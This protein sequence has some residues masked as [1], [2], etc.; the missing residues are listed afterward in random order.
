[1][2]LKKMMIM[3]TI[4]IEPSKLSS[5]EVF[6]NSRHIGYIF[7][8]P[9]DESFFAFTEE[10]I[11][12]KNR[13]TL[14]QSFRTAIGVKKQTPRYRMQLPPFFSNLLPEG[15]LRT[16]LSDRLGIHPDREFFFL[17]E[18][19]GDLPGA[20]MVQPSSTTAEPDS[21]PKLVSA[22]KHKNGSV[23]RFSLAGVQL[24]FSAVKEATG[25]LTI[26]AS[27]AGGSWIL[28]LPGGVH[29]A[30]TENEYSMLELARSVGINI[31]VTKLV[32]TDEIIGLPKDLPYSAIEGKTL[33][34]KRFDRLDDG[35]KV[36]IED[37]AQVFDV[38]SAKKYKKVGY[39]SIARVIWLEAGMDD[40]IEFIRRLVFNLLIGN[41]DMHSKNWSLIYPD[42]IHARLSPGYDFVSTIVYT[43]DRKLGLSIAGEKHMEKISLESFEQ[44]IDK[45]GLPRR[46]VLDSVKETILAVTEAWR[47]NAEH[48]PLLDKHRKVIETHMLALPLLQEISR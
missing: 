26:P 44:L 20:V 4:R 32:S 14:S 48:L 24:K 12:D 13:P 6:L 38:Y 8:V 2:N 39:T 16:Y 25:G 23:F 45:A 11:I 21:H 5:L 40:L 9:P 27:G 35:T 36:H 18:L 33:A 46:V 7:F 34:V 29:E 22:T 19:G 42:S 37:F 10:Y 17:A 31:P 1:M 47:K 3:K 30:V 43:S 41:A 15:H 28:K